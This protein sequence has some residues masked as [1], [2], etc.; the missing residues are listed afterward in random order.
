MPQSLSSI[1]FNFIHTNLNKFKMRET[2][3]LL[4]SILF[5]LEQYC[6]KSHFDRHPSGA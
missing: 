6:K 2:I 3:D 4:E 5:H 1:L